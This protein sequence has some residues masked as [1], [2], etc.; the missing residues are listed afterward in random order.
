M[1]LGQLRAK[2]REEGLDTMGKREAVKR[3]LKEHYKVVEFMGRA[4]QCCI[5]IILVSM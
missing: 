5:L 1:D 3:R 4:S 2:C